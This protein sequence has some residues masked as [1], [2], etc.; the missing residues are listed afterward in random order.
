MKALLLATDMFARGGIS[1]YTATLSSALGHVLGP[2]NLDVLLWLNYG[3]TGQAVSGFRLFGPLSEDTKPASKLRF[4]SA[5]VRLG[6]RRYDLVIANHVALAQVAGIIRLLW[7]TPF[8]VACHG[9]EVW[10]RLPILKL[11]ALK[12]AELA[13]P[14]SQFTA[15]KLQKVNGIPTAKT[16]ILHNAVPRQFASLLLSHDAEGGTG[17]AAGGERVLLSVGDLSKAHAYKGF[18]TVVRALPRILAVAPN[19]RYVIVGEGDNRANLERLAA[20]MGVADRVTFAGQVSDAELAVLY[21][22][23]KVFVMPSRALGADGRASG[24]GFGR[25]YV[26]AALASKPVVGSRGGGAAE[27]VLHGKTGFLVNP[28]SVEEVG[29]AV[30]TLLSD[31]ELRTS[32]GAAGRKWA[33]E[34]FTQQA[35]SKALEQLLCLT[36]HVKRVSS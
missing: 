5:S 34:N 11:A 14:I 4:I 21:R 22:T 1:R 23:C 9:H 8:W 27:A 36:G 31:T 29:D 13:L 25:V 19:A 28:Q 35:M 16:R 30:V 10:H 24:E 17:A 32:M 20:D 18:D 26:E 15:E 12:G 6:R 2:G 3:F 33:V 7:G